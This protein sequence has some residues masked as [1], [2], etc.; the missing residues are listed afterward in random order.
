MPTRKYK[1]D[2]SMSSLLRIPGLA[3]QH[4][5]L[6]IHPTPHAVLKQTKK[7]YAIIVF[8]MTPNVKLSYDEIKLR[9]IKLP[10]LTKP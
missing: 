4:L 5:N 10:D 2:A 7:R 1:K 6:P 8:A 3:L 9:K